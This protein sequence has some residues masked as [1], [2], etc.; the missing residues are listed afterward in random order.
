MFLCKFPSFSRSILV[1][2]NPYHLVDE[3]TFHVTSTPKGFYVNKSN[4]SLF[5]PTPAKNPHF[6]HILFQTLLSASISL[7]NAWIEL[8]NSSKIIPNVDR[9]I[10]DRVDGS[11]IDVHA[12]D[13]PRTLDTISSIYKQVRNCTL[14][15][16]LSDI[17]LL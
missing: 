16:R 5:D 9:S 10:V 7:R 6:S 12:D 8:C 11:N 1:T 14:H 2:F 4:K 17:L 3:G 15:L 13:V